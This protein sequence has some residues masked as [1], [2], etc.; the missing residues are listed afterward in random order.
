MEFQTTEAYLSGAVCGPIWWPVGAMC[1]RPLRKDLRGTWGFMPRDGQQWSFHDALLSLL[2]QE[3][4]DFQNAQFAA[5]TV[6][7]IVRKKFF[8]PGRYAFHR[9]EIEIAKLAPDLVAD[10]Y[11]SDFMGED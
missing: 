4:G 8:A 2:S 1:G 9:R 3:G 7:V 5:D 11:S 10:A 6:I